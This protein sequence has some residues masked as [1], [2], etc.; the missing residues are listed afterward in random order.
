ML[1]GRNHTPL[2]LSRP[3]PLMVSQGLSS[4][5]HGGAEENFELLGQVYVETGVPADAP[6]I[7]TFLAMEERNAEVAA[8][9]DS[10]PPATEDPDMLRNPNGTPY[11]PSGN[12]ENYDPC[13]PDHALMDSVDQEQI[14]LS[15]GPIEYYRVIVDANVDPLYHEQ[16]QKIF[17]QEPIRMKA[18]YEPITPSWNDI[19][20]GYS[21]DETG[22][23]F[24]FNRPEFLQL[25][26]EMPR[27]GSLIKTCDEGIFWEIV[28]L[29]VNIAGEDRKMW[30]KHRILVTCVKYQATVTDSSP[31]GQGRE[32]HDQGRRPI[33]VR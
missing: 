15:G 9:E 31:T 25:V 2:Q 32:S 12:A 22:M 26:G 7:E 3:N 1:R 23:G 8:Q 19:Q 11:I 17:L 16:R 30:G 20:V 6:D 5:W 4:G 27:I 14:E 13:N 21:S 28:K 18:V 29:G 33:N 24:S 10:S